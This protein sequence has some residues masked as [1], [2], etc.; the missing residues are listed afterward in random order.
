MKIP[1]LSQAILQLKK[2]KILTLGI[3]LLTIAI[4]VLALNLLAKRNRE[5]PFLPA[6]NPFQSP[7]TSL[8]PELQSVAEK[9]SRYNAKLDNFKDFRKELIYPIVDLDIKFD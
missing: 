7:A 3:L 9:I 1:N 5:N 8:D 2:P 6:Q 4:A